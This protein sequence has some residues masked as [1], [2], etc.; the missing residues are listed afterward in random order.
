LSIVTAPSPQSAPEVPQYR[1][2]LFY[3]PEP[4]E[5]RPGVLCCTF[6][7]KKRSWKGGVQVAVEM[8]ERQVARA[9]DLIG[10]EA[11]LAKILSTLLDGERADFE[12][13]ARDLFT[14]H[15]CALK[16]DL[17]IE[18]GLQQE[19]IRLSAEAFM[20]EL[21]AAVPTHKK[22]LLANIM[23]ELDLSGYGGV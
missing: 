23:A 13:R 18:A 12:S 5:D 3:G 17:A 19:N 1:I 10:F 22:R 16:L 11:W 21:D 15:L 9:R 20:Q 7:V 6:N 8:E 4:V 14:Q 2:T